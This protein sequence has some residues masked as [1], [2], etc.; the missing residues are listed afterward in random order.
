MQVDSEDRAEQLSQ[1]G[2]GR[3]A[4]PVSFLL[5]KSLKTLFPHPGSKMP[6]LPA[7]VRLHHTSQSCQ[8]GQAM[9]GG[10]ALTRV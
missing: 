1:Q 10:M 3:W 8:C 4:L 2:L 7:L 6:H 5:P 9:S